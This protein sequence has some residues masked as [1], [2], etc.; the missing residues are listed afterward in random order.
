MAFCYHCG[1]TSVVV[2]ELFASATQSVLLAGYAVHRGQRVFQALAKADGEL[3]TLKVEFLLDV[4][5]P[6]GDTT[7][8]DMLVR[9]FAATFRAQNWPE[10]IRTPEVYFDPRSLES[11]REKRASLHAKCVVVDRSHTGVGGTAVVPLWPYDPGSRCSPNF[12]KAP[13]RVPKG[14]EVWVRFEFINI[15]PSDQARIAFAIKA[16]KAMAEDRSRLDHDV[17]NGN[18]G[19]K[20]SMIGRLYTSTPA[21][22]GYYFW[23]AE[24]S[25]RT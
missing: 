1:D 2:R 19:K 22:A 12:D 5:R 24:K 25:T 7:L 3:P 13:F 10:R 11:T 4:Q 6:F 8:A 20:P 21:D 23:I 18:V 14:Q 17:G 16:D 9:R 15:E